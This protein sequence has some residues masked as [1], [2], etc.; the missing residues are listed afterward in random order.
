MCAVAH[1]AFDFGA[2]NESR[3]RVDDEQVDAA[4]TN[5][6]VG[7]FERLLAGV[8]LGDQKIVGANAEL[9]GVGDVERVLGVDERA[10]A[11]LFLAL[12]RSREG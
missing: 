9:A 11:A 2:R 4:R 7:D 1:L 5:E 10:N 3:D 8:R 12:R 6:H